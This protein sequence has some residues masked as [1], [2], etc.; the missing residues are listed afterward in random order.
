MN[1]S[2]KCSICG[3]PITKLVEPHWTGYV[4]E[5]ECQLSYVPTLHDHTPFKVFPVIGEIR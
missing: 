1:T 3:V 2:M 5:Y 4:D